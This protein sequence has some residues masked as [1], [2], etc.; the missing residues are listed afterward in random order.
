M[1]IIE[2]DMPLPGPWNR[3]PPPD[4]VPERGAPRPAEVPSAEGT[5][6]TARTLPAGRAVCEGEGDPGRENFET[7][8]QEARYPAPRGRKPGIRDLL[9]PAGIYAGIVMAEILGG[10]G[11]RFGRR[12][13]VVRHRP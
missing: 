2:D 12:P 8:R 9:S 10:R 13:P 1:R 6:D 7:P 3:R 4:T 5:A 11:G